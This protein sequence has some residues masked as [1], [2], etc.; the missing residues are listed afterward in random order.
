MRSRRLLIAV[1]MLST[2]VVLPAAAAPGDGVRGWVDLDGDNSEIEVGASDE[3]TTGK[4]SGSGG[5]S[6]CMWS[7]VP[8]DE[9]DDV[10]WDAGADVGDG[11]IV[12]VQEYDWYWKSC[13]DGTGGQTVDAVPVPRDAPPVDPTVLRDE[14]IDRLA[15]P[16]PSV[17]MNPSGD[18]VVHVASWLWIDGAIWQPH[19]ESVSAGGVTT[20]VTA[21]PQRVVW[22]LGN[23]DT[24]V[25]DGP[26]VPYDTSRPAGE[27]STDCSYT[28]R[29]TSA[30]Q[31]DDAFQVTAT[32]QW[33][34]SWSVTGAPGG[35]ALPALFTSSPVAVPVA[36]MQALNQ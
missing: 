3:Q 13:P 24:V 34:V 21:S 35:G 12:D 28:Y 8:E 10:W 31:P 18:Q 33:Q 11:E 22:D 25:C 20:T 2:L 7:R 23:G 36:E 29:H 4:N 1:G 32:V 27:Q 5:V 26:G 15:L 19:T 9:I 17:A 30:G 6:D 14:A 16:Q